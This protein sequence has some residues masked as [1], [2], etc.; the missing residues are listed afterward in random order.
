MKKQKG[1]PESENDRGLFLFLEH[2]GK[3]SI[4]LIISEADRIVA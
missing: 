1:T 4:L 3:K 2:F